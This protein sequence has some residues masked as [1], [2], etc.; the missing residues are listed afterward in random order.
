MIERDDDCDCEVCA[1]ARLIIDHLKA[2]SDTGVELDILMRAI[3]VIDIRPV[4]S[5]GPR[6]QAMH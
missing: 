5:D 2:R 4:G 1:E 3:S 6:S